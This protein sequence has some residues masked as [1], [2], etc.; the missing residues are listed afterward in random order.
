MKEVVRDVGKMKEAGEARK[1]IYRMRADSHPITTL[2]D[3][4]LDEWATHIAALSNTLHF[5]QLVVALIGPLDGGAGSATT[6][7]LVLAVKRHGT[8]SALP[9]TAF[10]A[11]CPL[12]VRHCVHC[13][14]SGR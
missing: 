13:R 1:I 9:P 6:E 2:K 10:S 4:M 11:Q 8:H 5:E 12:T 3:W 14:S 7:E